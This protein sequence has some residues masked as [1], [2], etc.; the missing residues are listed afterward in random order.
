MTR[1]IIQIRGTHR[2]F[3]RFY[4]INEHN[5]LRSAPTIHQSLKL[6]DVDEFRKTAFVPETPLLISHGT[7][8]EHALPAGTKW[9]T[10]PRAS[11]EGIMK[12]TEQYVSL[13]Y[14]SPFADTILPYELYIP[15]ENP[16]SQLEGNGLASILNEVAKAT[17]DS[18]FHRFNSPLGIFLQA[19]SLPPLSRPRLYIAQAQTTDLPPQLQADLPTP[20]L[21]KEAG[22]GDVYD[23]NI[24]MGIPPTY[25]PLHKD[26]NPNLFVQLSSKKRV[27][28]FPPRIGMEIFRQVQM[29]IGQNGSSSFRGHEMMEGPE[30]DALEEAVWGESVNEEGLEADLDAGDALFIPKGWWHSIKSEGQE[31][32]ASVNWWFR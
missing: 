14:L 16:H 29:A 22:K 24:W 23:A 18:T 21:V 11:N 9:F 15:P 2:L 10:R 7:T 28:L 5:R 4:S 26:P 19:S 31:V 6:I 27:R 1:A 20:R 3:R 13:E 25:T 8:P 30:R 12:H 17:P 32:N